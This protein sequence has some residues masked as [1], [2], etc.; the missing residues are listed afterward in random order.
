M[1]KL[2]K[3]VFSLSILLVSGNIFAQWQVITSLDTSSYLIGDPIRLE[4]KIQ[5]NQSKIVNIKTDTS[6][7]ILPANMAW[8]GNKPWKKMTQNNGISWSTTCVVALYDSG[9]FEIPK[10][11]LIVEKEG[12][13]DTVFS[14][15]VPVYVKT[16]AVSDSTQLVP[17]KDIIKSNRSWRDQLPWIIAVLV[18]IIILITVIY[19]IRKQSKKVKTKALIM[20][21]LAAYD[22]A[23]S[24]LKRLKEIEYWKKG[25]ILQ[26][27]TELTLII[28]EYILNRYGL[29]AMKMSSREILSN[30]IAKLPGQETHEMLGNLLEIADYVKFAKAIPPDQIHEHVMEMAENFLEKTKS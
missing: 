5:D 30:I 20:T 21:P 26:Y 14:S 11:P 27:Q 2:L 16:L 10:I 28:R 15:P 23:R 29:S 7:S 19:F 12:G 8:L 17:I 6:K 3:W 18:F 9:R 22:I 1:M 13:Y 25:K 4:F 24:Q